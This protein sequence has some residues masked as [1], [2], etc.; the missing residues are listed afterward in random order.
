[1]VL[2]DF[3]ITPEAAKDQMLS[4]LAREEDEALENEKV[5]LMY[6]EADNKEKM[7]ICEK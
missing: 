6:E 7:S 4:I 1:M 2:L 3:S 5:R